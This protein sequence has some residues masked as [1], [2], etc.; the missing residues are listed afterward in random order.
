MLRG[1]LSVGLKGLEYR[2]SE[3]NE[4]GGGVATERSECCDQVLSRPPKLVKS[5]VFMSSRNSLLFSKAI[6]L[7]RGGSSYSDITH[8]INVPKSTLSGWFSEIPWSKRM[9]KKLDTTSRRVNIR[10]IL[11]MN[12]AKTKQKN[13][14]YKIYR[15]EAEREY[16]ILKKDPLFICSLCLYW[17]EGLKTNDGKVSL[18][19]SDADL[20]EVVVTFYREILHVPENKIRAELFIYEADNHLEFINFWSKKI[21]LAKNQFIKTQVLKSRTSLTKRKLDHGMCNVYFSSTELNIKIMEWIRLMAK[22]LRA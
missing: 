1:S 10:R 14:R 18:V 2:T 8:R 12:K 16:N 22:D 6:Q 4:L 19:N 5:K 21:K 9:V 20:I 3:C 15:E 13:E 11:L 17:G 7:R